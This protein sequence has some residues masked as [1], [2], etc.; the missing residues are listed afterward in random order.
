MSNA[1]KYY[2]TPRE[3]EADREGKVV[4]AIWDFVGPQIARELALLLSE[5][6]K[7]E[8]RKEDPNRMTQAYD[9]IRLVEATPLNAR[10]LAECYNHAWMPDDELLDLLTQEHVR[11][12][13][14]AIN[15]MTEVMSEEDMLQNLAMPNTIT[16]EVP[17]GQDAENPPLGFITVRHPGRTGE[18]YRDFWNYMQRKQYPNGIEFS[19]HMEP[20]RTRFEQGFM[21]GDNMY[22]VEFASNRASEVTYA[23]VGAL[24]KEVVYA[25]QKQRNG[26]WIG[27][28]VARCLTS[29]RVGESEEYFND[30][31]NKR[32][33][34]FNK[35][36]DM[37]QIG[38]V[39]KPVQRQLSVPADALR[40]RIPQE[41]WCDIGIESPNGVA[42]VPTN[43]HFSI[44]YG[45]VTRMIHAFDQ[46][47]HADKLSAHISASR[48]LT[49]ALDQQQG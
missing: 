41:R 28:M 26:R 22:V 20:E 21:T 23:L 37:K 39:R 18:E 12:G 25:L 27:G 11:K 5:D 15:A 4:P 29:A 7:R 47:A 34:D 14:K 24:L 31:G 9:A 45:S 8:A 3:V 33:A 40:A 43:L 17:D 6:A 36:L 44:F 35:S 48:R 49:A 2:I 38:L 42:T 30:Q 16:L 13:M 46:L 19:G 32:I 10:R 1:P